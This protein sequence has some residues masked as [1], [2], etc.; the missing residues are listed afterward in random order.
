MGRRSSMARAWDR[1]KTVARRRALASATVFAA[2]IVGVLA[3][4]AEAF[5]IPGAA[6]SGSVSGGGTISFSVS[7]DGSSVT[8]LTLNG[9]IGRS[10]CTVDSKQYSQPIPITGQSFDNGEVS[11]TFP[12]VQGAYGR[13]DIVVSGLLSSCRVTGTWSAITHADPAGSEECKA[14][15]AEMTHAK[16]ALKKAKKAGNLGKIRKLRNRWTKAKGK[17]DQFC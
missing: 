13:F 10:E 16:R 3:P 8:N 5:H 2:L 7:G 11:G 1:V 9:P 6:Y 4:P 14:A 12:N 17:R 15:Q